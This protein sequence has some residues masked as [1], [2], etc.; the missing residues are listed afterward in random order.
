M[1]LG[2]IIS[3]AL[4]YPM[5]NLESLLIYIVL[6]FIMALVV[7]FTGIGAI[8]G[9]SNN[10]GAGLFVALIGFIICL[11]LVFAI[12]GYALDIIKS[13]IEK[14]QDGPTVDFARQ[15]ANGVKL[16]IVQFV[17]FIIP[18]IICLLL[19]LVFRGWIVYII[20][21]I[22][23]IIFGLAA[24]MGQCRLAKTEDLGFALNI[25]EAIAD[26]QKIGTVKVIL[27]IASIAVLSFIIIFVITAIFSLI[28]TDLARIISSIVSVYLLFFGNRAMGLLY[29]EI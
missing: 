16:F 20:G 29:S 22:L 26:L 11:I 25:G 9:A 17:Y 28:S 6:G 12:D 19:A 4:S 3:D 21:L 18:I 15:T 23:F 14:R 1:E 5:N 27:T 24:S 7:I 10:N 2:D 8:L 13:G